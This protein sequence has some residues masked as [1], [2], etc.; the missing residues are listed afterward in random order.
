MGFELFLAMQK[1]GARA[2]RG[3]IRDALRRSPPPPPPGRATF[4]RDLEDWR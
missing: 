4:M 1:L 3:P 2:G